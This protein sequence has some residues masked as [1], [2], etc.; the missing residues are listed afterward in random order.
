MLKRAEETESGFLFCFPYYF[1]R[2]TSP[3]KTLVQGTFDD[4]P[5]DEKNRAML[6]FLQYHQQ[7]ENPSETSKFEDLVR[8]GGIQTTTT[9]QSNQFG[10]DAGAL[11]EKAVEES[12]KIWYGLNNHHQQQQSGGA[13][14]IKAPIW[15]WV[16]TTTAIVF[17]FATTRTRLFFNDAIL[18]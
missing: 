6:Q 15:T 16:P 14:L 11:D 12:L 5:E 17:Y 8:S 13:K 4:L 1:F 18:K 10:Q 9:E 7:L 3:R 2:H